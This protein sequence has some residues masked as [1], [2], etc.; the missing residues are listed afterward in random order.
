MMSHVPEETSGPRAA[1]RRARKRWLTIGLVV[2][3]V[4][5]AGGIVVMTRL[6]SGTPAA[7]GTDTGA[8]A[9]TAVVKTDLSEQET[10]SGTLGYG[11]PFTITGHKNGTTTGLPAVGTQFTR[12][13]TV[14]TVDAVPVPL[15]YADLPFYRPLTA[16]MDDGPDVKELEQNLQALGFDDF[17]RPDNKFT[18]ATAKAINRWQKSLKMTQT[19]T[20]NPGDVVVEPGPIRVAEVPGQLGNPATGDLIKATGVNRQVT[21]SLPT[22]KQ[23]VAQVGSKV[24]MSIN[25]VST[26]GTVT[27][28]T[29]APSGSGAGSGGGGGGGDGGGS[30]LT[31]TV[32][33]D[34]QAAAA[35]SLD[36]APVDVVFTTGQKNG[37]LAVPVNALLALSGGGYGLDV[38]T[39][40]QHHLVKVQ[41]GLFAQG[42]VEV[43]GPGI[44][45]GTKVVTTS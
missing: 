26:T 27:S 2:V 19:G 7:K 37:V 14:Y 29:T 24:S 30:Q 42:Q 35:K 9:T 10:D 44:T 4:L 39:G 3:A 20:V 21:L 45:E 1:G 40:S 31:V 22:T 8:L 32:S 38:F 11:T 15:F 12:G 23:T 17:G 28:I 41:T 6:A 18:A 5:A 36:A 13:Q 16:G 43:S 34:D 25:G 33:I